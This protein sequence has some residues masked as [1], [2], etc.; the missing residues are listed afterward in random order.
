MTPLRRPIYVALSAPWSPAKIVT[1]TC[2]PNFAISMLGIVTRWTPVKNLTF[3]AEAIWTHLDQSFGGS[4]VFTTGAP[5]P[6]SNLYLPRS[7]HRL[8]QRSRSAQL[9]IPIV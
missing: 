2:N 8:L 9:L 5:Q 6:I 4:A 3:S 7:G 1:Y